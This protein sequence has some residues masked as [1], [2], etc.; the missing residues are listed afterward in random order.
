MSNIRDPAVFR[1]SDSPVRLHASQSRLNGALDTVDSLVRAG[2]YDTALLWVERHLHISSGFSDNS[3]HQGHIEA[4]SL[5]KKEVQL[6]LGTASSDRGYL[7]VLEFP[8]TETSNRARFANLYDDLVQE[9]YA[10]IV[11][12]YQEAGAADGTLGVHRYA[13]DLSLWLLGRQEHL[14]AV[15]P[16]GFKNRKDLPL[17]GPL[18]VYLALATIRGLQSRVSLTAASEAYD[19][20]IGLPDIPAES[21]FL[22][23][24]H[25]D[26]RGALGKDFARPD[27]L[28]GASTVPH[29]YASLSWMIRSALQQ[30]ADGD[31]ATAAT[32]AATIDNSEKWM[33]PLRFRLHQ[34]SL[35]IVI[36]AG[37]RNMVS[38]QLETMENTPRPVVSIHTHG[39]DLTRFWSHVFDVCAAKTASLT[40]AEILAETLLAESIPSDAPMHI[41]LTRGVELLRDTVGTGQISAAGALIQAAAYRAISGGYVLPPEPWHDVVPIVKTWQLCSG[42]FSTLSLI[43]TAENRCDS[44]LESLNAAHELYLSGEIVQAA[45]Q[46]EH[47]SDAAADSSPLDN[48]RRFL[49]E[50]LTAPSPAMLGDFERVILSALTPALAGALFPLLVSSARAAEVNG[51][52]DVS[53]NILK[54]MSGLF[55]RKSE[56]RTICMIHLAMSYESTHEHWQAAKLFEELLGQGHESLGTDGTLA[57]LT[58][59]RLA[60]NLFLDFKHESA[61]VHIESL[62]RCLSPLTPSSV[63]K[64][65]ELLRM[66]AVSHEALQH[67]MNARSLWSEILSLLPND[68]TNQSLWADASYQGARLAE[69]GGDHEAAIRLYTASQLAYEQAQEHEAAIQSTRRLNFCRLLLNP[70]AVAEVTY[71]YTEPSF[72]V[73]HRTSNTQRTD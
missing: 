53:Q 24:E 8:N 59:F 58:T 5:R 71:T 52:P 45:K 27:S 30:V 38:R 1:N 55:Q 11:R 16:G 31:F 12:D 23:G 54:V 49:I 2:Q 44:D 48:A 47:L 61:L 46:I 6:I 25:L 56:E 28:A 19:A 26:V 22:V 21:A 70:R 18:G 67:F 20:F 3:A 15:P 36:A 69:L 64:R 42:S 57:S 34:V 10:E 72:D 63:P 68:G 43:E 40:V 29:T 14:P 65:L 66:A 33:A 37:D 4:L 17:S 7:S 39:G 62:L 50:F 35:G 60:K 73:R 13:Y 51:R 41:F 9:H 32:F